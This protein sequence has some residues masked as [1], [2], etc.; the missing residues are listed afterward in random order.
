MPRVHHV[1]KARKAKPEYN[2]AVGDSYYWWKIKQTYGGVLRCSKKYPRPSQLTLSPFFG[3]LYELQERLSDLDTEGSRDDFK[4]EV[5]SIIGDLESL[6]DEQ[7]EKKS[8]L[9]DSLQD[10]GTGEQLQERYDALDN[11][12]TDLQ[13]VDMDDEDTSLEDIKNDLEGCSCDC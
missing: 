11:Y 2:I 6:R 3:P 8:N 4:S 13:A 12:I 1:L 5:E 7:E 9:P 10:S